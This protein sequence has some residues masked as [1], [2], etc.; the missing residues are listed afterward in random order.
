MTPLSLT[1]RQARTALDVLTGLVVISVAVALAGLTWR[2]AGHA[3]TGAITVPSGRSGPAVTPDIAPAIALAPFGK[4]AAADASQATSL[5]L[6]LKGVIAAIPAELSTAFISVSGAA[7]TP[8]RVGEA[9][10]GASIQAILRDRVILSANGR[11]EYLAFPDPTLSPEQRQAAAQEATTPQ[12]GTAPAPGAPPA[13]AAPPAAGA[14]AL[15]QRFDATPVSGGFRIGDNGPPG[16]VAGDVIQSVNGTSLGDP[17]AA[18]AAFA[19][20]QASGSAQIQILRDGKR[21]TLT[22]P[23]R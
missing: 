22:V 6:E 4:P 13:P 15:L 10:N 12:P 18:N 3:G 7:A 19:S 2:L 21:L 20:A 11:S 8:F 1:P 14:A 16:M 5:P 17:N 9:V 23:L